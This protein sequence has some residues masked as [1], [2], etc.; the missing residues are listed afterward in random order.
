M[1]SSTAW[2]RLV[3]AREVTTRVRDKT[4]LISTAVLLLLVLG[5]IVV[6]TLVGGGPARYD[7]AVTDPSGARLAAVT[8]DQLRALPGEGDSIVEVTEVDQAAAARYAVDAE[9]VD[10]ALL[11]TRDGFE[12]VGRDEVPGDLAAATERVVAAG[13]AGQRPRGRHDRR[14]PHR[15][16]DAEPDHDRRRG[17][18]S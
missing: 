6:G 11:P 7:V 2:W 8:E 18:V 13:A 16:I 14:N 12:I 15:R 5:G 4:F 9:E 10:A 3:A 17:G 1:S